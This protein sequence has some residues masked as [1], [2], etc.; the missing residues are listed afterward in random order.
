M[1]FSIRIVRGPVRPILAL[2]ALSLSASPTV[3]V[4]SDESSRSATAAGQNK[5]ER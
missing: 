2:N 5:S 4:D 3:I 1:V